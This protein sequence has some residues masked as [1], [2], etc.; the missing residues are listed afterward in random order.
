MVFKILA[1]KYYWR[2]SSNIILASIKVVNDISG[3]L[4]QTELTKNDI[5]EIPYT[6]LQ[7]H[8]CKFFCVHLLIRNK[9]ILLL[10]IVVLAGLVLLDSKI[11]FDCFV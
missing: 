9:K 3:F 10:S 6:Y 7:D 11:Y 1:L 5:Y 4:I 8:G 2:L